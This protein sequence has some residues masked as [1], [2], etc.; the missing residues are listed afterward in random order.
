MQLYNN[1]I[2]QLKNRLYNLK[3]YLK[4]LLTNFSSS[5]MENNFAPKIFIQR[6]KN[7]G[8]ECIISSLKDLAN[9]VER[10]NEK[11]CIYRQK[12]KASKAFP[13]V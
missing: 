13:T 8:K 11:P 5:K 1:R 4:K 3:T 7:V 12:I 10:N 6:T 2:Q 9:M